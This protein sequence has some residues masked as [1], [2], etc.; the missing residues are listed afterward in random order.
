M[1]KDLEADFKAAVERVNSH[2]EPFPADVLLRLYAYFKI[3]TRDNNGP[4]SKTP[5]IN[6]FKA[7]ALFQVQEMDTNEAK[8]NYVNCVNKYFNSL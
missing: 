8:Q 3:A 1:N 7:N 5:L 4:G 6:A 2:Q